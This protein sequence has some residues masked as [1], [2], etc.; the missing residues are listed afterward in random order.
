[1]RGN[2]LLAFTGMA[3]VLLY[4]PAM[5]QT[6]ATSGTHTQEATPPSDAVD[7]GVAD[8]VVTAQRQASTTQ[9]T[10]ATIDV[11]DASDLT[12]RGVGSLNDALGTVAGVFIQA[13][14]KGA[15]V[16]IR[17][18]GTGLD[19]AAGDPGV[20]TNAD[21]VYLRQ[22]STIV[23][24][25]YDID[26]IEVLKGPQGT[27]Y[28][29]NATGGAVNILTAD[30][31]FDFG[32]R[33]SVTVGNYSL[34]RT[35]AALNVPVSETLAVRAAFGSESHDGYYSTGQDDADRN[36][37]RVK[38]LWQPSPSL[39]LL[40]GIS[41]A[42]DGG[43]GPGSILATESEG[44]RNATVNHLPAGQ[45]D[46]KF[47]TTFANLEWDAGPVRVTF[48]PTYSHFK[49]DYLGTN[50]G[51]YSKQRVREKQVTSELRFSSPN[52]SPVNWVAGLYFYGTNSSNY[53]N[54]LDDDVINDQPDLKTRSYAGFADA[55]VPLTRTLRVIGGVRY[56]KDTKRQ[57][58]TYVIGGGRTIGPLNGE[59]KSDAFNFRLGGQLDLSPAIMAYVTYATGY[60]AG[61]FLPDEPGYNTFK[62]ERL[63]SIEGGVKSRLFGNRLQLN[64]AAFYY[65]Y[66]NY[67]VSTLGVA[68]YG[69]LSALVFNSQGRTK[70]YGAEFQAIYRPTTSDQIEL[71]LSPMRSKFGTF[72]IPATP[73]SP[74]TDVTGKT[75][76]SAPGLSGSFAYEHKWQLANG[77]VA[78][79]AQS[80]F[81]TSYWAEFSH[82]SNSHRPGYTRTDLNL[83]YSDAD[84]RWSIGAFVKN[85]ENS[86]IVTLKANT[87]VGD[88]A[89]QPPRTY[90]LTFT[91]RN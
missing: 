69:G 34:I 88:Y 23:S 60:K 84:D 11:L 41:F 29:R 38:L 71:N 19:A 36:A 75:L 64:V 45:L 14:N 8:I 51:F 61:G 46:Q 4:D 37:A 44:S 91:L 32:F 77:Q 63:R 73:V 67:Q 27:L 2:K 65:N 54:L 76:P 59:L 6:S 86:W 47:L 26:R 55:T 79:R 50:T 66:D 13:N 58:N 24:G 62:P 89:L 17:G 78:A 15:N 20:N 70:I 40:A 42:H 30:P 10:P 5:A 21:G 31:T 53:S 28:G 3:S 83:T 72:I 49:Y 18:V 43:V 57:E 87:Q 33:G 85:I 48:I 90:G 9:R 74:S 35:D 22:A 56:T 25:L 82:A 1:M 81:S 68:H 52:A 80:Y 7:T 16:N 39:R 12:S